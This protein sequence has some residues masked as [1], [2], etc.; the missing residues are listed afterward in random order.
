[1][2]CDY[3]FRF[4]LEI[5]A[6]PEGHVVSDSRCGDALGDGNLIGSPCR[7]DRGCV[8]VSD[9]LILHSLFA[10]QLDFDLFR[11]DLM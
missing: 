3:G 11:P 7:F 6:W 9:Q 2:E 1:M 5:C 8:F 10:P 4:D